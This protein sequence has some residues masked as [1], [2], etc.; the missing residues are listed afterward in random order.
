MATKDDIDQIFRKEGVFSRFNVLIHLLS[1]LLPLCISW[2]MIISI[3]TGDD[4]NWKCIENSTNLFCQEFNNITFNHND[5]QRC[6]LER[7]EWN[8]TERKS[9]SFVTE[10]DLVCERKY[11]AALLGTSYYIGGIIGPFLA[12][13]TGDDFGRKPVILVTLIVVF[14]STIGGSYALNIWMLLLM[15]IITGA[16]QVGCFYTLFIYIL[17]LV[18][19]KQRPISTT[20]LQTSL[21]TSCLAIDFISYYFKNWRSIKYYTAFPS[22]LPLIICLILPESPRWLLSKGKTEKASASLKRII[23]FNKSTQEINN[24]MSAPTVSKSKN[25]MDLF[26]TVK[27]SSLTL[28]I[29]AIRFVVFIANYTLL[30]NSPNLGGSIYQAF[31]LSI[32]PE[33]LVTLLYPFIGGRFGRRKA[34]LGSILIIAITAPCIILLPFLLTFSY[35]VKMIL[36]IFCLLFCDIAVCSANT[37]TF[38]LFPTPLRSRGMSICVMFDRIGIAITPFI[39]RLLQG[40]HYSLPYVVVCVLSICGLFIGYFMLPETRKKPT[41]EQ[42]EDYVGRIKKQVSESPKTPAVE[43]NGYENEEGPQQQIQELEYM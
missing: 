2:N 15:N 23:A 5:N 17:E 11:L 39:T 40:V 10:F 32:I 22:L 42:I 29:G 35:Q 41:R 21:M 25:Y 33:I 28:S 8:Y 18:P 30:C 34:F 43:N 37:W 4:P 14:L 31:A 38:E 27:R 3:F 24:S 20:I 12:G 7:S 1:L 6:R 36:I 13:A 16:G 9:Y 19:P 26:L